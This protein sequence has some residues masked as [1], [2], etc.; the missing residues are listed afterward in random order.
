MAAGTP[1]K[2]YVMAGG[3]TAE[4]EHRAEC[5]QPYSVVIGFSEGSDIS[6]LTFLA[7]VCGW[8]MG[9]GRAGFLGN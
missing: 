1:I 2:D 6:R 5:A 8:R 3:R 4:R 9:G 7:A